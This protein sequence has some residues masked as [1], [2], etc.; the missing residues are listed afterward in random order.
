[1]D[2]FLQNSEESKHHSELKS[3]L[4]S[5]IINKF[6]IHYHE[7]LQFNMQ[8]IVLSDFRHFLDNTSGRDLPSQIYY[9]ELVNENPDSDETMALIAEDLLNNFNVAGQDGWVVLVGDGKAYQHLMNIKRQY[10]TSFEK[11]LIFPGDWHIL[12]NYQPKYIIML[13]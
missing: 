13:V 5:Y 12:K 11:L 8:D 4:F 10:N 3:K 2:D 6:I 9:V 7:E 1:M